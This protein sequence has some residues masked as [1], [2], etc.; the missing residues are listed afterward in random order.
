MTSSIFPPEREQT[1]LM[2]DGDRK[3]YKPK[4]HLNYTNE[5]NPEDYFWN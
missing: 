2:L 1:M 4:S 5:G 3:F